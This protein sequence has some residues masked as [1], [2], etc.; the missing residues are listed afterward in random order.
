MSAL[1]FAFIN[2]IV[3]FLIKIPVWHFLAKNFYGNIKFLDALK[4]L[5][6]FELFYFIFA[7]LYSARGYGFL[8]IVSPLIIILISFGLFFLATK[9]TKLISWSHWKKGVVLFLLM[10]LIITPSLDHLIDIFVFKPITKN[11]G[12]S[13]ICKSAYVY[14]IFNPLYREPLERKIVEKMGDSIGNRLFFQSLT[15]F[16][17]YWRPVELLHTGIIINK[18]D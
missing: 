15:S 7:S 18:T 16:I 2:V 14:N 12:L 13:V 9:L 5:S 11:I 6:L 10:F 4:A 3:I 8:V 1:L 17:F